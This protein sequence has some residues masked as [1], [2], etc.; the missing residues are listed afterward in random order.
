[1]EFG[2]FLVES[3]ENYWIY[4]IVEFGVVCM[5]QIAEKSRVGE[6]KM[7]P[8]EEQEEEKKE[9]VGVLIHPLSADR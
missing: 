9:V 6:E 8:C 3:D 7:K 1:M 4:N 2:F 5:V